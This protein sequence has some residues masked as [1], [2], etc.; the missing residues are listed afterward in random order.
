MRNAPRPA[1]H[2]E[3]PASAAP[4]AR[5]GPLPTAS[6]RAA[7]AAR[8]A[9]AWIAAAP[10]TYLWLLL[11]AVNT[12]AL[13]RM[14]PRFRHWFLVHHSTNLAGLSHDPVRVLVTSAFWTETPSLLVWAVLFTLF[15]APVEQRLGTSRWLA[16]AVLAHVGATLLSEGGVAVLVHT[17]ALP[18]R[19]A[20]T[21]DIGVS[22]ALAGSVGVLTWLL[23]RRYRPWYG[24]A[25]LLFFT[26]LC[27]ADWGFTNA[28][29]FLA[30]AIG[31]ACRRLAQPLPGEPAATE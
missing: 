5:T 21:I 30:F 19:T 15:H 4:R 29:H 7:L 20:Y 17:G 28:G 10:G 25:A 2:E 13:T 16:V 18:H 22:Y 8:R 24:G 23:P 31:T 14:P 12:V 3:A 1:G 26:S 6:G 11:L 27:V 9:G